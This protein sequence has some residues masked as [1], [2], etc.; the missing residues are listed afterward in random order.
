[1]TAS[2]ATESLRFRMVTHISSSLAEEVGDVDDHRLSL[3]TFSGLAFLADDV[4]AKVRFHSIADYVAGAGTFTLYP[5]IRF[6]DDSMLFL[7]SCG[8]GTV[9][10][11]RTN[12]TGTVAVIGGKKRFEAARGE[13]TLT[14]TRYTPLS[15]GADLVSE[16]TVD[17]RR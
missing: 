4:V 14:G 13:G 12:F 1:M 11:A 16:Y 10:G 9:D 5:V 8:T 15:E 17:L 3:S 6:D 2:S 7:K